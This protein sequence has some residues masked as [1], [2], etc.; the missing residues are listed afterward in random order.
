[1]V[2]ACPRCE[3]LLHSS[4]DNDRECLMCGYVDYQTSALPAPERR[5]TPSPVYDSIP[6]QGTTSTW[7][8]KPLT[9]RIVSEREKDGSTDGFVRLAPIRSGVH[10]Y[11]ILLIE[12]VC[13]LCDEVMVR[14][15][16]PRPGYV[17]CG[18]SQ[19]HAV[20]LYYKEGVYTLWTMNGEEVAVPEIKELYHPKR[21]LTVRY[22]HVERGAAYWVE[23]PVCKLDMDRWKKKGT[24]HWQCSNGHTV[25]F[26]KNYES[27]W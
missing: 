25:Q 18:C 14:Q 10:V 26:V 13:P 19:G 1:M 7:G 20:K 22:R 9:F 3:G 2:N 11:N 15:K 12:P 27:W 6:Y 21:E 24:N 16:G 17:R 23:C 5:R 8:R 4:Y